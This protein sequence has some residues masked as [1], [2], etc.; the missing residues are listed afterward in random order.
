MRKLMITAAL[1][2]VALAGAAG[3]ADNSVTPSSSASAST[4]APATTA[5]DQTKAVCE[6]AGTVSTTAGEAISAKAKEVAAA[7]GDQTKQ[8][9]I[10]GDLITLANDWSAKLTELSAKPIKPEV[11]QALTDGATT[12]KGLT[13][14]VAIQTA[15]AAQIESQLKLLVDKI[16]V[17]CG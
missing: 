8:L 3:C 14:P 17:A 2:T 5:A 13:N 10:A 16:S 4:A 7:S 9:K 6:E 12:I 1:A 11:K 15:N